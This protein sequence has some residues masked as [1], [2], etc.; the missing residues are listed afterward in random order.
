MSQPTLLTRT[1]INH[2]L[3]ST[4]WASYSPIDGDIVIATSY[5]SGTTLTQQIL[6]NMLVRNTL[7]D[8]QFPSLDAVSPWVDARFHQLDKAA[9]ARSL[10]AIKHRRFLKSHLPLDGLPFYE[11]VRY[12][13]VGRDPRDVFVSLLN[14]YGN[15]TELAYEQLES[16]EVASMPRFDGDVMAFWKNW[17]TRGWF[18]WEC[19]GY[20]FWSNMHH[21]QT[22]WDFRVLPNLLFLHYADMRRDL[23]GTLNRIARFIDVALTEAELAAILAAVSFDRVKAQAVVEANSAPPC[24]RVFKGGQAT[25][26]N[27]G[28]NGRWRELLDDQALA[29]YYQT[30]D[31]VL[32]PDCAAWLEGGE[33]AWSSQPS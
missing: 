24:E 5:K 19:E 21:T 32:S 20:P 28:T 31:R 25:F 1:Y 6:Y 12:I 16:P 11:Q 22:W 8:E 30:R 29:L 23:A 27:E 14:H 4:R 3:D 18:D 7:E 17:I 33:T 2:H 9:L 13:V 26:I 15:Y 10:K